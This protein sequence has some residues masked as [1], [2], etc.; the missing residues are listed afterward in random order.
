MAD[1]QKPPR[2]ASNTF[3]RR[4]SRF[5]GWVG[6]AVGALMVYSQWEMWR[7]RRD[8]PHPI[9]DVTVRN[10]QRSRAEREAIAAH[11]AQRLQQQQLKEQRERAVGSSKKD[12]GVGRQ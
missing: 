5:T 1:F 6:M 7:M 9:D 2:G 3:V 11:H 8:A 10:V 4:S 12:N